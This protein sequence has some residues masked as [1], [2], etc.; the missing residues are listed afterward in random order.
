MNC[1]NLK[2]SGATNFRINKLRINLDPFRVDVIVDVPKI[3]AVGKYKLNLALGV[4]TLK[5]DGDVKANIGKAN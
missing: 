1:A 5:G 4:L 2:A 3:E